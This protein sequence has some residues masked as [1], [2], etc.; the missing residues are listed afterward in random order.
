MNERAG[1][2]FGLI[3]VVIFGLTLPA[4]RAAIVGLDPW[5]VIYGRGLVAA[6]A[7]AIVL[8]ATRQKWPPRSRWLPL[9]FTAAC[10]VVGFPLFAT[11]A[12]QYV[13]ASHGSVVLAILPLATAAAGV[14]FAG[15]RPSFGFWLC[16]LAGSLAVLV[17]ALMEGSGGAQGVQLADL[18]LVL[19][20]VSAA[21]GYAVG[22]ELSRTMCGWQVISWALVIA[23]PALALLFLVTQPPVN[24]NAAASAWTGFFYLAL[25][26][27]FLGFFAW[28]RGLALGGVAKIGQLQLLQTFVTLAA[29]ALLLGERISRL[30]VAFAILVVTI[31]AIGRRMRVQRQSVR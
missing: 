5:F 30:E 18:F 31:V 10:I 3:G 8:A 11:L 1:V 4:T 14:L 15:E 6:A 24:W 7:A 26:S 17:F 9:A 12:M 2:I 21:A 20:V 28:Y 19:A 25:F 23:A 27:Q 13:P 29:A 22:A 16:G